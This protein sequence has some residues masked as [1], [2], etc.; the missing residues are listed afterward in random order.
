MAE[1]WLRA[2]GDD[3]YADRQE[4]KVERRDLVGRLSEC[5]KQ[6]ITAHVN[7]LDN[8]TLLGEEE[9]Q[10]LCAVLEAVFLYGWR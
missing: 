6:L 1:F 7:T 9:A 3:S 4:E 5:V 10:P 2:V 8:G